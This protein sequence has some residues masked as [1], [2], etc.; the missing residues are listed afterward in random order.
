MNTCNNGTCALQFPSSYVLMD[1]EEMEYVEGGYIKNVSMSLAAAKKACHALAV[2]GVVGVVLSAIAGAGTIAA[3]LGSLYFGN[4]TMA[5][6]N[7]AEDA[8]YYLN[9]GYGTCTLKVTYAA[10]LFI[11]NVQVVSP[12]K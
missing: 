7:A 12:K 10:N 1:A 3:A 5:A 6:Y 8:K 11:T 4:I 2:G 9:R